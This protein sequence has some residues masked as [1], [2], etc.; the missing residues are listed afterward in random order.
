MIRS[1]SSRATLGEPSTALVRAITRLARPLVRL[2]I[3]RGITFPY[4]A[5]LLKTV[6]VAVA[7]ESLGQDATTSRVSVTTGL[8]RKDI[9]RI[10]SE[11]PP[12]AAPPPAISIGARLIGIWT[13][14]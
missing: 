7:T 2:L 12:D 10:Q 1:I 8:Q 13:G 11:P 9:R 5:N 4:L 6:Y 3:A 14:N